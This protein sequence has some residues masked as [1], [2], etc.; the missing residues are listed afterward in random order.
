MFYSKFI[1]FSGISYFMDSKNIVIEHTM[2][3]LICSMTI[4]LAYFV[5]V[6]E[7]YCTASP[8]L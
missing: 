5:I 1:T 3:L 8:G 2:K 4:N 6:S 7:Y